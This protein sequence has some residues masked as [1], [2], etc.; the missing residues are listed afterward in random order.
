MSALS[1]SSLPPPPPPPVDDRRWGLGDAFIALAVFFFVSL[2][3]GIFAFGIDGDDDVLEGAWLPVAVGLPPAIQLFHV[4]WIGRAKGRGVAADFGFRFRPSDLAVGAGVFVA[5]LIAAGAIGSIIFEVFD[6][7]PSASVAEMAEDSRGRR[8]HHRL[9]R[10]A[11]R[12]RRH[13][14]A[15]GRGAR[16]P[17]TV[18]ERAVETRHGRG[19]LPR[20]HVGHLR[21]VPLR[22]RAG[23][24]PLRARHGARVRPDPHRSN[25]SQH[26]RPRPTS[27]RSG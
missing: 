27:T 14:R 15:G 10:A 23:A 11:R 8:R 5:G 12:A 18:V 2:V 4:V 19:R 17:G 9:D 24:G 13:P 1:P 26:R 20:R 22:A 7:E 3:V 16:V 25:R 21:P 6:Q